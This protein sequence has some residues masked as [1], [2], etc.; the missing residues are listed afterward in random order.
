MTWFILVVAGL[1]EVVWSYFMKLSEGFSRLGP[2]II[3]LTAMAASFYLLAMAMKTIP[4][5]SAYTIW[6]G[7]G[8]AGAFIVDIIVL[9]EPVNT[10]RITAALLI[11]AGLVLMKLSSG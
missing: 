4:L 8:V 2:S 6:T 3:T 10:L 5:G 11:V 1:L 9:G 7:I